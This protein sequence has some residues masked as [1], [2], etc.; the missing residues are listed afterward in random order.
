MTLK[1]AWGEIKSRKL[2]KGKGSEL[3]FLV[4]DL[5]MDR[6]DGTQV[7]VWR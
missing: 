1:R 2:R 3:G 7:E 6:A 4:T 5:E